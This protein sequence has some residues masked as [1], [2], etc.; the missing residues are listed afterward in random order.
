MHLN[1]NLTRNTWKKKVLC[2]HVYNDIIKEN[3]ISAITAKV[4]LNTVIVFILCYLKRKKEERC[5]HWPQRDSYQKFN[6]LL[7]LRDKNNHKTYLTLST[8]LASN[9][10]F[11][12][13]Q[14][15]IEYHFWRIYKLS[16][17]IFHQSP[18]N[19]SRSV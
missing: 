6:L 10:V 4:L 15:F 12:L 13:V 18:L 19:I 14:C 16:W 1:Y 2:V 9:S 17:D 8:I 5:D 11:F 7:P 3:R